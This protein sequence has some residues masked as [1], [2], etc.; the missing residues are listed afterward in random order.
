MLKSDLVIGAFIISCMTYMF[1]HCDTPT[2]TAATVAE[3]INTTV[4][5]GASKAVAKLRCE[6]S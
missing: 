1:M 6:N 3:C 4:Q 2:A 5:Q